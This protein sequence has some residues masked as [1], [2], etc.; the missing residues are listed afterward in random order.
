VI[1]RL[2]SGFLVIVAGYVAW[3]SVTSAAFL[4]L[5]V[6]AVALVAAV[7]L[8]MRKRWAQYLW[9]LIAGAASVLW[10]ATVAR[11]AISGWPYQ[12]VTSSVISLIPGLLLLAVCVFGSIAVWRHFRKGANAL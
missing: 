9:Y 11:V 4:W 6:A 5:S 1:I 8:L 7:G 3:W 12:D 10:L 2:L